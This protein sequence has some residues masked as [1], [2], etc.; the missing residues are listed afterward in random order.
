[1]MAT[2]KTACSM[3]NS[4]RIPPRMTWA[5]LDPTLSIKPKPS[6]GLEQRPISQSQPLSALQAVTP[7]DR[8]DT[9]NARLSETSTA[10]Q[11]PDRKRV[12]PRR[13]P[14]SRACSHALKMLLQWP[15]YAVPAPRLHVG[16][17]IPGGTLIVY[18]RASGEQFVVYTPR[19]EHQ[20]HAGHRAGL[21]YLRPMK[22][23]GSAPRS[24]SFS[25]DRTTIEALRDGRWSLPAP[26]PTRAARDLL[27]IWDGAIVAH[28]ARR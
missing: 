16:P 10:V 18:D 19:F 21:W 26:L 23:V 25:S 20:F 1:M 7:A 2:T 24:L 27:N 4:P 8:R 12:K 3:L 14:P 28:G 11:S 6:E 13:S 9:G 5:D 17:R 15:V 22:D